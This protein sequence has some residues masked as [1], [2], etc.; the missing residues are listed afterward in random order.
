MPLADLGAERATVI[1]IPNLPFSEWTQV[2][3]SV[4]LCKALLD[5]ITD[6]SHI[7]EAKPS[8]AGSGVPWRNAKNRGTAP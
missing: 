5:R 3:P 7:I 1:L 8:P 4:R 6:R 2:F